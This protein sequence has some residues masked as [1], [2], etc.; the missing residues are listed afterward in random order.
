MASS[1][2][3]NLL[4]IGILLSLGTIIYCR[5]KNKTLVDVFRE[6]KE[7]INPDE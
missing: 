4:V 2:F 7:I 5:V 3:S 1:A 6:I